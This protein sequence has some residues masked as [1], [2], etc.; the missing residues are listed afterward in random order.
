M[1][2]PP[3]DLLEPL[4]RVAAA[5]LCGLM[6]A[7]FA[8]QQPSR[9][10]NIAGLLFC[11]GIAS[12]VLICDPRL[13]Q[14][15]GPACGPLILLAALTPA[16]FWWFAVSLFRDDPQWRPHYAMP[17][18]LL[19]A[20]FVLRQAA[21]DPL[22]T[23]GALGHQVT[24]T[25]LLLHVLSLAIRDFQ[26]DLMDARRRFRLAVAIVLP[27]TGLAIATVETYALFRPLP[28]WIGLLQAAVVLALAAP[29]ALWLTAI[30]P[31][32]VVQAAAPSPRPEALTPADAIELARLRTAIAAGVCLEPDL[33]L[34]TL[35]ERLKLPEHRLRRLINKGLGYR[36]FAAFLNDHRVSQA[37]RIL[38]DPEN[39]RQHIVAVAFELGYASLAPFNRAFRQLTGMTPS[40][41]RAQALARV[42]DSQKV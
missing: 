8:R 5:T 15:L 37:K 4:V 16:F 12:Y 39:S 36:N 6:A 25:T 33:S 3:L 28:D 22:R 19:L 32:L 2:T 41:Y 40:E 34:G 13:A 18:V 42:G 23:L 14:A 35:S 1:S 29:F 26:Q 9:L 17:L 11:V 24:V 27:A 20:L 38:A 10:A 21:G 7:Q 30:R 31:D